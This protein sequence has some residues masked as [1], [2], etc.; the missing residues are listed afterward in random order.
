MESKLKIVQKNL[1]KYKKPQNYYLMQKRRLSEQK[2]K[3]GGFLY[4]IGPNIEELKTIDKQIEI[5]KKDRDKKLS[6]INQQKESIKKIIANKSKLR[7]QE[8]LK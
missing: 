4:D 6:E 2:L 1:S 5:S 8:L 3:N 7:K